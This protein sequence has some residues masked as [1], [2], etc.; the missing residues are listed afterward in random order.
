MESVRRYTKSLRIV[1]DESYYNKFEEIIEKIS[2]VFKPSDVT[3]DPMDVV[4]TMVFVYIVADIEE[5]FNTYKIPLSSKPRSWC[6]KK[7][8]PVAKEIKSLIQSKFDK[9]FF[10][11]E[12]MYLSLQSDPDSLNTGDTMY[13]LD[14]NVLNLEDR[15]LKAL[16]FKKDGA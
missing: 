5:S 3:E 16:N 4:K 2:K 10:E 14:P 9:T 12:K 11:L 1:L 7:C 15:D 6:E 13:T 8:I